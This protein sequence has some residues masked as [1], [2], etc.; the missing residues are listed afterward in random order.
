MSKLRSRALGALLVAVAMSSTL[1][2]APSAPAKA[3]AVAPVSKLSASV[4]QAVKKALDEQRIVGA[5]VIVVR[6]G[7]VVY[8]KAHG[9]ADR[10]A[11]TPMR[12]DQVFR[13]ASMTK[14]LVAL[15]VL[16]L[17]EQGA[18]SLDAPVTKYLPEFQPKLADGSTPVIT[19]R[20]LITHTSGLG[21]RFGEAANGPY[22]AAGVSD[23]LDISG[24]TLDEN[25]RRIAKA[26]LLAAPGTAFHYSLGIDVLGRVV[27]KVTKLA[28]PAA[29]AKLITAPL[30]MSDTAFVAAHP[31]RLATPYA[32]GRSAGKAAPVRMNA[33][34]AYPFGAG[35][36][37]FAP[38]RALDAKA[39]P[40]GGAGMVG[41]A[42]DYA[43]FLEAVRT[44]D[45]RVVPA[46]FAKAITE[47]ATGAFQPPQ[48]P[49]WGFGLL[50]A[51]VVDPAR[52]KE[53][54]HAGTT[55]W[56]GVYGHT[57]WVDRDAKLSVVLL[58]N[59]AIEGMAGK[60]TTDLRAA[61][62]SAL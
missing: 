29:V 44:S 45:A 36:V 43:K 1:M 18:L 48:G 20:Q 23:G 57:W 7:Q 33:R 12:V 58:T 2:A 59:T 22:H 15:S 39:Y 42:D 60:L 54:L 9:L 35:T 4:D 55:L 13:L 19:L 11:K 17:A 14:P 6:D 41:T 5:V 25:L 47:N 40:S 10:E 30:E 46:S 52:A 51:V 8:R 38:A 62:Y 26:P 50:G 21:Y 27:E 61:I 49:G 31:E 3:P 32:D 53:P 37:D 56:G 34:Y 28:L 16:R 24:I